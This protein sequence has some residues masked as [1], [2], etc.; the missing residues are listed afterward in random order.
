[1]GSIPDLGRSHISQSISAWVPQLLSPCSRAWKPSYRAHAP[2]RSE[3]THPRACV[4]QQEKPLQWEAPTPLES[5][6]CLLQLEKSQSKAMKTQHSQKQI[7]K[8]K[9][10]KKKRIGLAKSWEKA[11][12]ISG[13]GASRAGTENQSEINCPQSGVGC[14]EGPVRL[15]VRAGS[16]WKD[17]NC[18]TSDMTLCGW[19][20]PL[21]GSTTYDGRNS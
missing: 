4:S 7:N 12:G 15:L 21:N 8:S 3:L 16:P 2:Q 17:H 6:P 1:M 9:L 10:K 5:S 20:E 18:R 19:A 11:M 13:G 14:G